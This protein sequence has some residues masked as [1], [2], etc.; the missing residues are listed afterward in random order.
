MEQAVGEEQKELVLE[1]N[2]TRCLEQV[3]SL[4]S[5]NWAGL[6]STDFL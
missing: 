3:L 6:L 2:W 1:E 5:V 4:E